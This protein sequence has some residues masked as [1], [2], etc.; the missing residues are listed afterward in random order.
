MGIG[1]C[2]GGLETSVGLGRVARNL[3]PAVCSG[4]RG[5]AI[6]IIRVLGDLVAGI[7]DQGLRRGRVRDG[8]SIGV[9][10]GHCSAD[11]GVLEFGETSVGHRRVGDGGILGRS[12]DGLGLFGG[13]LVACLLHV[14][15]LRKISAR[16]DSSKKRI[17][18][19]EL[20]VR[21]LDRGHLLIRTID[22]LD[23]GRNS[24]LISSV[25]LEEHALEG[26]TLN[27]L[28]LT[29]ATGIGRGAQE[30]SESKQLLAQLPRSS[31]CCIGD[32][33]CAHSLQLLLVGLLQSS[34][35][36][37]QALFILS[38]KLLIMS[39][40]FLNLR[41][42]GL[43]GG[44]LQGLSLLVGIDLLLGHELIE[45]F[46]RVLSD[47]GVGLSGSILMKEKQMLASIKRSKA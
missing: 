8:L 21:A 42:L 16:T 34:L 23:H 39:E 32:S 36:S 28:R 13:V 19:R 41:D 10:G 26:A 20:Q 1:V 38:S 2:E 35:L 14:S 3:N 7:G 43:K 6:R 25:H 4:G 17:L 40:L 29:S 11:R 24:I 22:Q 45:G 18:T 30:L 46:A 31:L 12:F 9:R 15:V 5:Q 47:D 27:G 37:G 33:V 44:L